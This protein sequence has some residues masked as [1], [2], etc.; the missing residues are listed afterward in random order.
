MTMSDVTSP[1]PTTMQT[2]M[3]SPNGLAVTI[4]DQSNPAQ[5][6]SPSPAAAAITNSPPAVHPSSTSIS[7]TSDSQRIAALEAQLRA[8]DS[9]IAT[10]R[11]RGNQM[12]EKVERL[13]SEIVVVRKKAENAADKVRTEKDAD[14]YALQVKF[15]EVSERRKQAFLQLKERLRDASEL[16]QRQQTDA[17]A[18]TKRITELETALAEEHR[19]NRELTASIADYERRVHALEHDKGDLLQQTAAELQR[20]QT[21]TR[22]LEEKVAT[23]TSDLE[24]ASAKSRAIEEKEAKQASVPMTI[25]PEYGYTENGQPVTISHPFPNGSTRIQWLRSFRGSTFTPIHGLSIPRFATYIPTVD[26][27]GAT[28]RCDVTVPDSDGV[29]VS[30]EFGPI[31]CAKQLASTVGELIKKMD[32][33]FNVE[34][35][36]VSEEMMRTKDKESDRRQILLNKEKIKLRA[37]GKTIAK[38]EYSDE[39]KV[40]LEPDSETKFTVRVDARSTPMSFAAASSD[41]RATIVQTIRCFNRHMLLVARKRNQPD[42][43]LALAYLIRQMNEAEAIKQMRSGQ[44]SERARSHSISDVEGSVSFNVSQS[45]SPS[46]PTTPHA[47][48]RSNGH[49]TVSTDPERSISRAQSSTPS[50]ARNPS[51]ARPSPPPPAPA[52]S[53]PLAA[54]STIKGSNGEELEVDADGFIIR[55]QTGW[56]DDNKTDD[57]GA[58]SG[59]ANDPFGF[60][61]DDD[62]SKPAIQLKINQ[63]AR[64]MASAADLRKTIMGVGL[65]QPHKEKDKKAATTTTDG[66]GKIRKKKKEKKEKTHGHKEKRTH[67]SPASSSSDGAS[68]PAPP[69]P[70]PAVPSGPTISPPH[71]SQKRA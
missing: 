37:G 22:A 57:N 35:A 28:L 68:S 18:A 40:T 24:R 7:P 65:S 61:D 51:F 53:P 20:S 54:T 5:T 21:A 33:T 12:L 25:R 31:Y 30:R 71:S 32:V 52:P 62:E 44:G 56:G 39:L 29:I 19:K 2:A 45:A 14:I 46:Q 13:E 63:E 17:A 49:P 41:E 60:S 26:D 43:V 55:R 67:A 8:K 15:T 42:S 10:L 69:P 59:G 4:A 36:H 66:E 16:L 47:M 1:D 27:I 50:I 34:P 64:P 70:A 38:A 58:A 11:A 48:K 6:A 9:E 23:L 3:A